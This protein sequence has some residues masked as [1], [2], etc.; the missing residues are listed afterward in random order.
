MNQDR[1]KLYHYWRSSCSW[2]VRWALEYKK[3]PHTL[4]AVNLLNGESEGPEH[5]KRNPAGFVPVL[6]T[7]DGHFLT[8]SL[9]II[10][11]LEELYPTPTLFPGTA[12]DR[13]QA[14]ALAEIVNAG[15]QPLQNI[16]TM[17]FHSS[18]HEEQK[19]W[20]QHWILSGLQTYELLATPHAGK[21][22]RGDE[23]SVADLCL[24]PQLY[25][26]LRHNVDFSNFPTISRIFENCNALE[27]L[28]RSHPDTHKPADF[29]A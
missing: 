16:P 5:L 4:I 20:N 3:I 18:D 8:E 11:Y 29:Q 15:I 13:A 24:M 23:L 12:L 22:S 21:F 27:S 6:E 7:P 17:T 25:N 19:R 10:R 2:R 14:W 26:A 1:F 9:G 28:K